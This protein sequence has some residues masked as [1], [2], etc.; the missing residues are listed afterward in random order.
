MFGLNEAIK[1][2]EDDHG[3]DRGRDHGRDDDGNANVNEHV[4]MKLLL[5]PEVFFPVNFA[6]QVPLFA[7]LFIHR[8]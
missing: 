3:H 8:F 2:T 1:L 5:E 4:Q 7:Y 6:N